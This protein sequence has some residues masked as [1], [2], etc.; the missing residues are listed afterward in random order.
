MLFKYCKL[1]LKTF[2][3]AIIVFIVYQ[4]V[5]KYLFVTPGK[6]YQNS[7]LLKSLSSIN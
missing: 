2:L 1:P 6:S 7:C 5:L 3:I 4:Q